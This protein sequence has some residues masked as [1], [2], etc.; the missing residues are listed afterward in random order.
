MRKLKDLQ[1]MNSNERF[2]YE[3][4]VRQNIIIEQLNSIVEH[5]SKKDSVAV[6]TTVVQPEPDPI[7]EEVL[8]GID[9]EFAQVKE[10]V[11]AKPKARRT[12]KKVE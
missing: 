4:I 5:I 3:L 9:K 7:D 11:E 8:E 6:Q 1:P 12:R 2:L 10:A